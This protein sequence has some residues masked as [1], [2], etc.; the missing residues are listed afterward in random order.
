ME[1]A[2]VVRKRRMV[3]DFDGRPVDAAVLRGVVD[4]ACRV[5]SAGFTQGTSFLVLEGS[6]ATEYWDITL[7]Q[8][9]RAMFPWPGL[10]RAPVLI[11]PLADADAYVDRYAEPDKA[12]TGLG[13][14]ADAWSVPYWW[15][16]AGLAVQALLYGAVDAGLGALFFGIFD[17]EPAVL[18]HFG[19]PPHLRAVGTVAI[20]HPTVG[21]TRSGPEGSAATRARRSFDSQVHFGHW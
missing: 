16:D 5:P 13:V 4:A 14:S 18:A 6:D 10:L 19:V 1:Y 2:E 15:V 8:S 12:A 7:T 20:G 21:A 9:K 3:R 11:L 17:H